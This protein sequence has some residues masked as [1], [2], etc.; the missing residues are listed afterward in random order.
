[1]V[2]RIDGDNCSRKECCTRDAR[3]CE[4]WWPNELNTQTDIDFDIRLRDRDVNDVFL[5][6]DFNDR[7]CDG[8]VHVAFNDRHD[9]R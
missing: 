7:F 5:R 9:N 4:T 3:L 1:M 6:D 8:D 2:V